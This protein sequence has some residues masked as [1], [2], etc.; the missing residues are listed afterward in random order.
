M[1]IQTSVS[2]WGNSVGVRIPKVFVQSLG[3]QVGIP[4]SLELG[5][6]C[7]ILKKEKPVL[8]DLLRHSSLDV[9]PS[10]TFLF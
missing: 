10:D 1:K 3:L 6:D 2:T 4:L 9:F 8:F 5:E 7:L